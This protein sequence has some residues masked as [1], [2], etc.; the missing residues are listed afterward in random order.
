ME[1]KEK[2][3]GE[4]PYKARLRAFFLVYHQMQAYCRWLSFRP[5]DLEHYCKF[6]VSLEQVMYHACLPISFVLMDK[7]NLSFGTRIRQA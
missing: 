6:E 2:Y 4:G 5:M 3:Y 7:N 1:N